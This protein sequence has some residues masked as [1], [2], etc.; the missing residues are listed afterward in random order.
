MSPA[1]LQALN[2]SVTQVVP[3]TS[4]KSGKY[5]KED[6]QEMLGR[7]T[8]DNKVVLIMLLL[9]VVYFLT[10][11]F[12]ALLKLSIFFISFLINLKIILLK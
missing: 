1:N 10:S 4:S 12:I 6:I 9:F 5:T 3:Q 7:H 8:L 11:G 2:L